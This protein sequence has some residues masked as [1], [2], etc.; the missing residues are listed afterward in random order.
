MFVG[1]VGYTNNTMFFVF[2]G[3]NR[4]GAGGGAKNV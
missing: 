3:T 4:S 2:N 1:Q